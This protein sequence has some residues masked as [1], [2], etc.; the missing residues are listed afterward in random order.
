MRTLWALLSR[1]HSFVPLPVMRFFKKVAFANVR[2]LS[3]VYLSRRRGNERFFPSAILQPWCIFPPFFFFA[4]CSC[5]MQQ[6][7]SLTLRSNILFCCM[8]YLLVCYNLFKHTISLT[9]NGLTTFQKIPLRPGFF[10]LA[11]N[12]NSF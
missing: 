12:S 5:L 1:V 9:Y 10:I 7:S 4:V 2:T 6:I 11:I 8:L 3:V